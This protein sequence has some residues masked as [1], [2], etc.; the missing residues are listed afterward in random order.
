MNKK[1]V[2]IFAGSQDL[3]DPQVQEQVSLQLEGFLQANKDVVEKIL[4]GG[5]NYGVMKNV[6]DTC[7]KLW[8]VI[9]GYSLERYRKEK[10]PV[11]TLYFPKNSDRL[12]W[13]GK[14]WDVFLT[15][16]G[17]IGTAWE[18]FSISEVLLDLGKEAPIYISLL[19]Q[20]LF[21]F[22]DGQIAEGAMHPD[23]VKKFKPVAD[24]STIRI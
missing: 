21:A 17:S 2:V 20:S 3:K 16:P 12:E 14:Q 1:T 6:Y 19:S 5:W 23:Y 9:E 11:P 24:I 4:F 8:I 10:N 18:T 15:L 7:N 13:F 22:I